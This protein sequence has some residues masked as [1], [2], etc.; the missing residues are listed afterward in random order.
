MIRNNYGIDANAVE[1]VNV[2]VTGM[3]VV[4]TTTPSRTPLVISTGWMKEPI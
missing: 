3:N 1:T 4:I 2:A